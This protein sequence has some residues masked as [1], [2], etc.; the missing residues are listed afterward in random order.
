MSA[1]KTTNVED[2]LTYHFVRED[3]EV[4]RITLLAHWSR[5]EN[6]SGEVDS[7]KW[8]GG[9]SYIG[10]GSKMYYTREED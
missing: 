5:V 4:F 9:D 2:L 10:H 1:T 3:G 8:I 7:I 6:A